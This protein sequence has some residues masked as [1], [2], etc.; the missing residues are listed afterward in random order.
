VH[1]S[2]SDSLRSGWGHERQIDR[3]ATWAAFPLRLRKRRSAIKMQIRRSVCQTR[4]IASQQIAAYS[5]TSSARAG[6]IGE[7]AGQEL[8][9]KS[10]SP[11]P[12]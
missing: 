5:I 8:W 12:D 7:K 3:L 1:R 6:R 4:P 11:L 2:N 10:N 9:L